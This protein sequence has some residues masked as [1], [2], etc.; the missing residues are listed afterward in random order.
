MKN[1]FCVL[2]NNLS[3]LKAMINNMPKQDENV[4]FFIFNDE[5]VIDLRNEIKEFLIE[6]KNRT[7]CKNKFKIVN[8]KQVNDF[9]INSLPNLTTSGKEFVEEY[10]MGLNINV[11]LYIMDKYKEIE[12][13]IFVDDDVLINGDLSEIFKENKILYCR[14]FMSSGNGWK[15][16]DEYAQNVLRLAKVDLETWKTFNVNS[17]CRLFINNDFYRCKYKETITD[18]YNNSFFKDLFITYKTTGK[19]KTKSFF[20]DQLVENAFCWRVDSQNKEMD[21]YCLTCFS[22]VNKKNEYVGF[23]DKSKYRSKILTHYAIGQNKKI[24][25]L[26]DLIKCGLLEGEI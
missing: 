7:K 11:Q 19:G 10:T 15:N 25:F 2:C 9:V 23:K 5:R 3:Y 17:G 20:Q 8:A 21:K 16:E 26:K 22:Y 4:V 24:L 18:F 1:A 13:F 6:Y 14:N 12:K